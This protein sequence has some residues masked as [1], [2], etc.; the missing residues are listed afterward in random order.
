[1]NPYLFS[2][3]YFVLLAVHLAVLA[4]VLPSGLRPYSK[5]SL[6]VALLAFVGS[7]WQRF[8]VHR[9][10]KF[11][12]SGLAMSLLGDGLLLVDGERWFM[13]GLLAFLLAHVC[14]AS[15]FKDAREDNH[16]IPLA[17]KYL[18]ITLGMVMVG[19][20]VFLFLHESME[21]L[22]APVALYILAITVMAIRAIN[23]FR[24]AS[25]H[26]FGL[27]VLGAALFMLSDTLLATHLFKGEL[28]W[29]PIVIMAT[30]GLAQWCIALGIYAYYQTNQA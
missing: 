22:L 16:E 24:K 17:Q 25:G 8:A 21:G 11:L 20:G 7:Q 15:C 4:D 27:V 28:E 14:Y 6:V 9:G 13:G 10:W 1:M 18:L 12:T 29:A 26:S 23:R 30:Y 3:L 2:P 19:I 5:L